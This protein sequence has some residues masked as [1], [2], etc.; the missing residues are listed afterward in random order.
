MLKLILALFFSG[1]AIWLSG[2]F[3]EKTHLPFYALSLGLALALPSWPK[4]FEAARDGLSALKERIYG[5]ANKPL[6]II[7]VLSLFSGVIWT[8]ILFEKQHAFRYRTFD[9]GIYSD[10]VNNS[11]QGKLLYSSVHKINSLGE[12]FSPIVL[13]FVPF[14]WLKPSVLW[15]VAAMA[16]SVAACPIILYFLCREIIKEEKLVGPV[17]LVLALLWQFYPPLISALVFEFHPSTL[18]P[19]W[20]LLGF[21]FLLRNRW[22]AFWPTMFLLLLFKENMALIW[23]SF[24]LYSLVVLKQKRL[25]LFLILFGAVWGVSLLEWLIPY[26]RGGGEWKHLDRFGPTDFPWLKFKYL[27]LLFLPLSFLPLFDLR[28]SLL[29]W[30]PILLNL[31]VNYKPQFSGE[32]QY[33]DIIAPLLFIS[34]ISGVEALWKNRSL[35]NPLALKTKYIIGCIALALMVLSLDSRSPAFFLKIYFPGEE[36][37]GAFHEVGVLKNRWPHRAM[38]Y[39]EA[40]ATHLNLRDNAKSLKWKWQDWKFRRGDIIVVSPH[41]GRFGIK[42]YNGALRYLDKN[43]NKKFKRHEAPFRYLYVYEAL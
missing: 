17:A 10:I 1:F 5:F 37:R 18:A 22:T 8:T 27:L 30:P 41:L 4:Q 26:F 29:V 42:D 43:L 36:K 33:N 25:G 35:F 9:A 12:H 21:Y 11:S 2:A 40:F 20:I 7:I 3:G 6:K 38:H 15:L 32:W 24:G 16:L 23:V 14:Y 19:P 28:S 39:Q 31:A 13:F 34:A